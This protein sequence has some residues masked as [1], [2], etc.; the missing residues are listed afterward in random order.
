MSGS[1]TSANSAKTSVG[2]NPVSTPTVFIPARRPAIKSWVL[3]PTI[4]TIQRISR[5]FGIDRAQTW[6]ALGSHHAVTSTFVPHL[7][8]FGYPSRWYNWRYD[9]DNYLANT[10]GVTVVPMIDNVEFAPDCVVG[11]DC[12][13]TQNGPFSNSNNNQTWPAD[14]P[15]AATMANFK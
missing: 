13:D 11:E 5:G 4:A 3:S 10:D 9:L 8:V 15:D 2:A 14:F 6:D 7:G 1:T 12:F